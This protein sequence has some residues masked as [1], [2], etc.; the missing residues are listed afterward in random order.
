MMCDA[1]HIAAAAGLFR[2]TNLQENVY[3]IDDVFS[4]TIVLCHFERLDQGTI[5]IFGGKSESKHFLKSK[6]SSVVIMN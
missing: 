6:G 1:S 4:Y 3:G 5:R 2:F